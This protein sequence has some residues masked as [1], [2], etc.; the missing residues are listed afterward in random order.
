MIQQESVSNISKLTQLLAAHGVYALTIIFIFYQQWRAVRNLRAAKPEDHIHFRNVHSSVLT[1]TYILV[2]ISTAVW[3]YATFFYTAKFYIKGSVAGLMKRDNNPAQSG[4]ASKIMEDISPES[5]D[6]NIYTKTE[7]LKDSGG[8]YNLGWVLFP[9]EKME[10]VVFVL[11]HRYEIDQQRNKLSLDPNSSRDSIERGEDEERFTLDLR[12]I[13]YSLGNS[14]Q[15]TYEANSDDRIHRA[16]KI[17][18]RKPDGTRECLPWEE[19]A[20]GKKVARRRTPENSWLLPRVYASSENSIFKENGDYDPA[21]GAI[22]KQR[23]N[24]SDLKAQLLARDVLVNNGARSF[25]FIRDTLNHIALGE[26]NFLLVSNLGTA[27]SE[28]ESDGNS[29]PRDIQLSL[30]KS[31][32]D[33]GDNESSALFFD[34]AGNRPFEQINLYFYRGLAYYKTK[35]YD[36]SIES[37]RRFA[38]KNQNP[39]S[40]A[41]AH[42]AL[43][44]DYTS[45]NRNQDAI[46]AYKAAIKLYPKFSSPYNNLAYVYAER[47]ANLDTALSLVN[48]A[49]ALEKNSNEVANQKD[50]KGWILYKMGRC[51][52]ALPLIKEAAATLTTQAIIKKHLETVQ[53]SKPCD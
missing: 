5:L 3:I 18:L 48:Q 30:A 25:K 47:G 22:L 41:V 40:N 34:K 14:I 53:N 39:Y 31:F 37:L 23:L 16:G 24:D 28:I 15:L 10:S 11:Q 9:P 32:Y 7:D 33:V 29:T 50:T 21:F 44:L 36:K 43:G 4:E 8:I 26:N 45:S 49:L 46:V 13:P 2:I 20:P 6:L 42:F 12:K 19:T 27:V 52:E 51:K 35:Q 38:A 1:V 17:Y